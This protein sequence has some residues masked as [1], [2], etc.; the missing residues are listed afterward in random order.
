MSSTVDALVACVRR[1]AGLPDDEAA[2]RALDA[3]L[4]AAARLLTPQ[5]RAHLEEAL[6]GDLAATLSRGLRGPIP[7]EAFFAEVAR[8]EG[9]GH[10]SAVA[11]ADAVCGVLERV[12]G[13]ACWGKVDARLPSAD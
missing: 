2:R 7:R 11:H 3:T 12:L 4:A 6:P 10:A 8:L 1:E 13:K 9:V 5:E